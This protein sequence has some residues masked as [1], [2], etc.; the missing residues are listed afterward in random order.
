MWAYVPSCVSKRPRS[1]RVSQNLSRKLCLH[2]SGMRSRVTSRCSAMLFVITT[3][4]IVS[5]TQPQ[6][7]RHTNSTQHRISSPTPQ[8]YISS[9]T[10]GRIH[11]KNKR[12]EK[13]CANDARRST[14]ILFPPA[15]SWL[16]QQLQSAIRFPDLQTFP[17]ALFDF[18][19]SLVSPQFR[20]PL[21]YLPSVLRALPQA[22]QDPSCV[23]PP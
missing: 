3:V 5:S 2:F 21:L 20:G 19:S 23:V 22:S 10:P 14:Y 6:S 9:P 13:L 17:R 11:T 4:H 8:P 15:D 18:L 1:S 12:K 16:Y 7:Y